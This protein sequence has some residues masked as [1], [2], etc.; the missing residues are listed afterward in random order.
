MDK[1]K[2]IA[3]ALMLTFGFVV[4]PGLSGLSNVQ[5]QGW[6]N[7]QDRR[8]DRW[9]RRDDRRDRRDDRWDRRDDRWDRRDDRWD[10]RDDRWDRRDDYRYNDREVQKGFR[11]GLDRGQKD[12]KTRRIADPNNSS[13]YRDGN[14]SYREGFRRGYAQGYRQFSGRRW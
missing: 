7:R 9:D 6:G 8:D 11:D 2:K 14:S 1:M 3:F 5:A 12:A 4:A 13:H 10:R